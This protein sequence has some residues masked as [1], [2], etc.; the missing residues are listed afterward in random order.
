MKTT[1]RASK[2]DKINDNPEKP[3]LK[4]LKRDINT[5][6]TYHTPKEAKMIK[7]VLINELLN[8]L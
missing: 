1:G 8:S 7:K 2:Y 4:D 6:D 3:Y 5:I